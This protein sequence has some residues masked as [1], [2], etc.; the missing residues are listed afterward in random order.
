MYRELQGPTLPDGP[1]SAPFRHGAQKEL[2]G[3]SK[4]MSV[5]IQKLAE[6]GQATA[7]EG[8]FEFQLR[9]GP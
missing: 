5:W 2:D 4:P 8:L 3:S 7:I 9:P 1:K 6:P